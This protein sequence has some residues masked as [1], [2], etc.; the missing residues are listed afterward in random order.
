MV[1]SG[2][3]RRA[4]YTTHRMNGP[5]THQQR[6]PACDGPQEC[7]SALCRR[8]ARWS[9]RTFVDIDPIPPNTNLGER[10]DLAIQVLL[11]RRCSSRGH[12]GQIRS[13]PALITGRSLSICSDSGPGIHR[14]D[15]GLCAPAPGPG[16]QGADHRC[17]GYD[18]AHCPNPPRRPRPTRPRP[19][20]R[21][22]RG[23]PSCQN[24]DLD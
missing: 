6:I 18:H 15:G 8:Q 1:L 4:A 2:A 16:Q 7:S 17:R 24:S 10:P 20:R 13:R 5:S 9:R 19:T 23:C 14:W 11:G 12:L 21:R 3:R 22:R